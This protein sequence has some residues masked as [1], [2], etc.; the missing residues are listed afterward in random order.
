M[1]M[2]LEAKAAKDDILAGDTPKAQKRRNRLKTIKTTGRLW[3]H[4]SLHDLQGMFDTLQPKD[5][6]VFT[7]VRNPWDRMVSYYHWLQIQNFNHPA[8]ALS[9]TLSFKEFLHH[10]QIQSSFRKNPYRSYVMTADGQM[11]C[12]LFIRLEKL[13]DDMAPLAKHLGFMPE[14]QHVNKSNRQNDYRPYYDS[15]S[16]DVLKNICREDINQFGYQF[17]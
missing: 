4:S 11:H 7:I 2:A 6:F 9:K 15:E 5:F 3:K 8:V 14:V 12:D 16:A 10:P 13:T 17:D 1:A